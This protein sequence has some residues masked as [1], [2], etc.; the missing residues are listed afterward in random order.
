MIRVIRGNIRVKK[1][2]KFFKFCKGF[3]QV[4]IHISNKEQTFQALYNKYISRRL[5]KRRFKLCQILLLNS[6]LKNSKIKIN[7]FS[8]E[9]KKLKIFLTKQI[10]SIICYTKI[11]IIILL[12]NLM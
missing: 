8:Y 12:R 9:L 5:K 11:S 10:L 1:R 6:I 3:I 2:K 4:K 7:R